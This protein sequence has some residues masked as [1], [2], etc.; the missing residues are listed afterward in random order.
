MIRKTKFCDLS[1]V[2]LSGTRLSG[3]F[4]V[5]DGTSSAI[6]PSD[7]IRDLK[8]HYL[9]L[10]HATMRDG[11]ATH[12]VGTVMIRADGIAHIELPHRGWG[13]D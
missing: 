7:A 13:V 8:E 6:R 12:D 5:H 4:H 10:T 2:M 3:R 11:S 9:I 1:V